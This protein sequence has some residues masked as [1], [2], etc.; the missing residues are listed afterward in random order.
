MTSLTPTLLPPQLKQPSESKMT[1]TSDNTP[2]IP[3]QLITPPKL[4]REN[5]GP[6][7]FKIELVLAQLKIWDV[8]SGKE[9]VPA[10]SATTAEKN[11]WTDKDLR[12]K[13]V[14]SNSVND[15]L[16]AEIRDCKS[17]HAIWLH[18]EHLF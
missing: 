1:V 18:L 4:T 9:K 15:A 2:R 8:V 17:A 12:A 3:N 11:E 6:W 7:S 14:I 13:L 5:Y 16:I 10:E